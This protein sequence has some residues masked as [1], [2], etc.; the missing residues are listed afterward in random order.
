[1]AE[2]AVGNFCSHHQNIGMAGSIDK[3]PLWYQLTS[4]AAMGMQWLLLTLLPKLERQCALDAG[5]FQAL[6]LP[7]GS[8]RTLLSPGRCSV[9]CSQ[10]PVCLLEGQY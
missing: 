3:L 4:E 8:A 6:P 7:L 5:K 2:H 10:S 1:M 9:S